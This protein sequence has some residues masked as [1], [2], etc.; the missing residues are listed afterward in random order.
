MSS[1]ADV[2]FA[3]PSGAK[4]FLAA[5]PESIKQLSNEPLRV[6]GNVLVFKRGE[7]DL[8]TFLDQAILELV[9]SREVARI[10]VKH[11]KY[12][13]SFMLPNQPYK[14]NKK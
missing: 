6:F 13:G 5:N 8:K 3:E 7:P 11:E 12:P 4:A 1:K 10:I 2:T 14:D 9:Y